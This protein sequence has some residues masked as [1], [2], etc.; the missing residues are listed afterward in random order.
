MKRQKSELGWTLSWGLAGLDAFVCEQGLVCMWGVAKPTTDIVLEISRVLESKQYDAAYN[1]YCGRSVIT[2]GEEEI[3]MISTITRSHNFSLRTRGEDNA[4]MLRALLQELS[5]DVGLVWSE[6][7]HEKKRVS[8]GLANVDFLYTVGF[9]DPELPLLGMIF[10]LK[11]GDIT[12]AKAK[13]S[14]L[15]AHLNLHGPTIEFFEVARQFQDRGFGT[16]LI[17][18]IMGQFRANFE[19]ILHTDQALQM[20][21]SDVCEESI[22]WFRKFG[23]EIIRSVVL[24][25]DMQ[26]PLLRSLVASDK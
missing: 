23:F 10:E 11:M 8:S 26:Q 15:H 19:P 1:V 13:C 14:N 7:K 16:H 6:A 17:R 24:G 2:K 5:R 12:V 3:A 25:H 18:F 21:V 9:S 4:A 22:T 20:Y